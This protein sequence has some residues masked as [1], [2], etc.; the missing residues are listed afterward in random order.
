MVASTGSFGPFTVVSWHG[1]GVHDPC[2]SASPVVTPLGATASKVQAPFHCRSRQACRRTTQNKIK[3]SICSYQLNLSS[4]DKE[5]RYRFKKEE[6]A[7]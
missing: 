2:R 6:A 1:G 7:D 5:E 3:C 4:K